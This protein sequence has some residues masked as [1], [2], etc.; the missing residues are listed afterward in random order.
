MSTNKEDIKETCATTVLQNLKADISLQEYWLHVDSFLIFACIMRVNA[1]FCNCAYVHGIHLAIDMHV[2]VG[3]YTPYMV[4][5][6]AR[7]YNLT[8]MWWC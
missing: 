2:H 7:V 1:H 3:M 5:L 4:L 8:I 6:R